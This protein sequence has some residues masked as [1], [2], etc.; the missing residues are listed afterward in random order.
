MKNRSI[1]LSIDVAPEQFYGRLGAVSIQPGHVN[2]VYENANPLADRCAENG[3]FLLLQLEL[4]DL[5]STTAARLSRKIQ[6]NRHPEPRLLQ[7]FQY[8]FR[9]YRF[10]DTWRE[11][12][13]T[14]FY[15]F[16][17]IIIFIKFNHF[18]F[19]IFFLSIYYEPVPPVTKT[20]LFTSTIFCTM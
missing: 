13:N 19:I 7:I 1:V 12:K 16:T 3:A 20:A 6:S 5:L 11:E 2:V 14:I 8:H 17:F 15:L 9:D 18:Y 4:E 10:S